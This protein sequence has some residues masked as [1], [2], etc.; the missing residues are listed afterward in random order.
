MK[1]KKVTIVFLIAW[2]LEFYWVVESKILQ[3]TI[4]PLVITTSTT[5]HVSVT[6]AA[7]QSENYKLYKFSF[8]S[9]SLTTSKHHTSFQ[10]QQE[11]RY[12]VMASALY[13]STWLSWTVKEIMVFDHE[14]VM[15]SNCTIRMDYVGTI[16]NSNDS[17]GFQI[18][19]TLTNCY[20]AGELRIT[21]TGVAKGKKSLNFQQKLVS[22]GN[23]SQPILIFG[24][25]SCN[26]LE[27]LVNFT[28][29]RE[30]IIKKNNIASFINLKACHS[31]SFGTDNSSSGNDSVQNSTANT[32]NS[33]Q[34]S[35]Q[36]IIYGTLNP[37][38]AVFFVLIFFIYLTNGVLAY[39]GY[40]D[41]LKP[42]R[43]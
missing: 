30:T 18:N 19:I 22:F 15:E 38:V 20:G 25:N 6:D 7:K 36:V 34:N 41:L 3:I 32:S 31:Y 24:N 14:T 21:E 5:I 16:K 17:I 23:H 4:N 13:N 10:Y 1:R 8:G 9:W 40:K 29:P 33:T 39:R 27:A 35:S 43:Y 26:V 28:T 42:V 37:I 11:G 12:Q 2:L